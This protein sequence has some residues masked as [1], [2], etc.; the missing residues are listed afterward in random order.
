MRRGVGGVQVP[1]AAVWLGVVFG[2][3]AGL[4]RRS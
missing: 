3:W 2:V 1:T 4:L